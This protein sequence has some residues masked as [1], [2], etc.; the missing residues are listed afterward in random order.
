MKLIAIISLI[1]ACLRVLAEIYYTAT[2]TEHGVIID[3]ATVC[4]LFVSILFIE[5][6]F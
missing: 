6:I 3:W 5:C 2:N 1:L 4:W